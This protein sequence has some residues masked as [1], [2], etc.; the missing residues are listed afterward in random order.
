VTYEKLMVE[1]FQFS[2]PTYYKW[3]KHENRPIFDLLEYAFSKSNLEEWVE[4]KT[5]SKFELIKD[6]ENILRGSRLDYLE[7]VSN[8][9]SLSLDYDPF[10]DFYYKFLIY[11]D[12]L[13]NSKDQIGI[14]TIWEIRDSIP[15]FF[16]NNQG[17]TN[18]LDESYKY[19]F[20]AK[21]RK[22]NNFDQ[23]MSNFIRLNLS[24]EFKPLIEKDSLFNYSEDQRRYAIY[25][26]LLFVIYKRYPNFTY[27]EKMDKLGEVLGITINNLSDEHAEKVFLM[28]NS[29]K[30]AEKDFDK[31]LD[32]I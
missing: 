4:N 5:I 2:S 15:G 12:E 31:Y 10:T 19:K 22:I 32:K 16:I 11:V 24:K 3:K 13:Q 6:F 18:K 30:I 20:E 8:N 25:H 14:E 9:L 29:W 17:I 26:A 1:L 28:P 23:N 21:V 27:K 7:F